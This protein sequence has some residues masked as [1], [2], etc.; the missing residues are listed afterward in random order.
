MFKSALI[1][2]EWPL[3]TYLTDGEP[4]LLLIYGRLDE[5]TRAG[6]NYTKESTC[7]KEQNWCIT[8]N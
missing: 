5:M 8:N 6:K 3:I 2:L 4:I 7:F 1:A